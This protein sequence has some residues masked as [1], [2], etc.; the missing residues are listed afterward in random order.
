[1]NHYHPLWTALWRGNINVS[2]VLSKNAAT[3]YI[4][5]YASK[6]ETISAELD[7]IILD[8]TNGMLDTDGIQLVITKTLNKFC[9]E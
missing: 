9:I 6:A 3:N 1:M 8:L 7:K 5:K 4:S 2:P